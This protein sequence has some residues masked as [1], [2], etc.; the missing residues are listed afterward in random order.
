MKE[1]IQSQT[2][3]LSAPDILG[4]FGGADRSL[5]VLTK[6]LESRIGIDWDSTK[7]LHT[8]TGLE[9]ETDVD[10]IKARQAV[11][12]D[13]LE[14]KELFSFAIRMPFRDGGSLE[15]GTGSILEDD[16]KYL[17]YLKDR[18]V[19]ATANSPGLKKAGEFLEQ[20]C[21]KSSSKFQKLEEIIQDYK[22]AKYQDVEFRVSLQKGR[23]R[24]PALIV[25]GINISYKGEESSGNEWE[26]LYLDHDFSY[27]ISLLL[28]GL[29]LNE[30]SV[31]EADN[32]SVVY[33]ANNE[34][35]YVEVSFKAE[36]GVLG[37]GKREAEVKRI[38][39]DE[40]ISASYKG[41]NEWINRNKVEVAQKEV[42]SPD[43]LK[44]KFLRQYYG[45]KRGEVNVC[46]E[47]HAI[48]H[49]SEQLHLYTR[50]A[51]FGN[52]LKGKG[53]EVCFPEILP[54]EFGE[55]V[56]EEG[57]N[58]LILG[59]YDSNNKGAIVPNNYSFRNGDGLKILTGSVAG[60]KTSYAIGLALLQL[61]AQTGMQIPAK[62]ARISVKDGVYL[63]QINPGDGYKS[64][65]QF[66]MERISDFFS[67]ITPNSLIILDEPC[68]STAHEEGLEIAQGIVDGIK[69]VGSQGIYV[70][71]M[72]ELADYVERNRMGEN[73][74]CVFEDEKPTYRIEAGK[75]GN[76][77]SLALAKSYGLDRESLTNRI[78]K[79]AENGW[80]KGTE[81]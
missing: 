81:R 44:D 11:L 20:L 43:Q 56:I 15:R 77:H 10:K 69:Q 54:A 4:S 80:Q 49:L 67:Q 12:R 63:H 70:T 35:P 64:R 32:I 48:T 40:V 55:T 22:V 5:D 25:S 33:P 2:E 66:E 39:L 59:R 14:N 79:R 58:P 46:E 71:H 23:D 27:G 45:R 30:Q 3:S 24:Y 41:C 51:R 60:G 68:G 38:G 53:F 57:V 75:A 6:E 17:S 52:E 7:Y 13:L 37:I 29:R 34:P 36:M 28:G 1:K 61:M 50:L 21:E 62:S 18:K 9:L 76:S 8:R 16:L 31:V 78:A 72:H 47:F 73:L 74:H 42:S 26:N 19:L 65:F